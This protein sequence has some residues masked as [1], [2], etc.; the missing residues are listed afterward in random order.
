MSCIQNDDAC[1]QYYSDASCALIEIYKGFLVEKYGEDDSQHPRFDEPLWS[2]ASQETGGKNKGKL[3]GL[4][5]I[6]IQRLNKIIE[7]LVKEKE[8]EKAE[9]EKKKAEKEAMLER[10][11]SIESLLRVVTKNLP[12]SS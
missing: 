4:S 10:M 9:K 12:S 2:R 11:A 1:E 5:S 8:S 3:Y 7:E 6:T